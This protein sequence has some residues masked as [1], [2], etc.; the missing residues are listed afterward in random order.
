L[1]QFA[2]IACALLL[3][4]AAWQL[5]NGGWTGVAAMLLG[6]GGLVGLL[7]AAQPEKLRFVYVGLTVATFPI[8]WLVSQ[9]LLVLIYYGVFTP[10]GL[11][12]RV[13]GRDA[14]ERRFEPDAPTYWQTKR[15]TADMR[16]YL[17]QY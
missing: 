8:G 7:G 15:R 11:A 2:G 17:R 3:A 9:L 10:V 16:Q 1:R 14:L 12:F 4:L 6:C 5:A 13:L